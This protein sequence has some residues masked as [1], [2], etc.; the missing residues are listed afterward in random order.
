[1]F[2]FPNVTAYLP[3]SLLLKSLPGV[4]LSVSTGLALPKWKLGSCLSSLIY[5]ALKGTCDQK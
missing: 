4:H 3:F 5:E 2:S 1:M